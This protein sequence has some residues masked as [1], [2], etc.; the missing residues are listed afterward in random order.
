MT[1]TDQPPSNST[2]GPICALRVLCGFVLLLVGT[3]LALPG[4]PG[5][6]IPIV[7]LGLWLLSDRFTW[8]RRAFAWIKERA[9]RLRRTRDERRQAAT[10][11]VNDV[12]VQK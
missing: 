10:Q 12:P 2:S 1:T 4:V 3:V 11:M 9:G 8:A 5:P 7:L 6:G